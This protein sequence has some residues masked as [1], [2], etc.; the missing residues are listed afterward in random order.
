MVQ[1]THNSSQTPQHQE[2]QKLLG[3]P[4]YLIQEGPLTKI[5]HP[6]II[7][8]LERTEMQETYLNTIK[9]IF[10]KPTVNTILSEENLKGFPLESGTR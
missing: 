7:K 3:W 2:G 4:S 5:Q 1:Y 6:F 10:R 9:A 8:L